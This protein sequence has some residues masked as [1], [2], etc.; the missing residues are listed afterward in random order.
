MAESN[1]DNERSTGLMHSNP[2]AS[3]STDRPKKRRRKKK[4]KET[5][6]LRKHKHRYFSHRITFIFRH[7]IS[8]EIF[9]GFLRLLRLLRPRRYK[10]LRQSAMIQL[11]PFSILLNNL[12]NELEDKDLQNLKNVCTEF[13]PR[14]QREKIKS[15]WEVFDI[16]KCQNVIGSK[17][18]KVATLL[19]II[20]ELRRRD[21]VHM[22]KKHIQEHY[23]QP[24]MV[25]NIVSSVA[26]SS[27]PK[28]V[29]SSIN[30]SDEQR[31]SSP[32]CVHDC[33][34][35]KLVC[36]RS[37]CCDLSCC[38]VILVIFFT[39]FTVVAILAWYADIPQITPY[40]N[41]KDEL[42]KAGPYIIGA[43]A[44][45]ALCSALC[46]IYFLYSRRKDRPDPGLSCSQ[47]DLENG[48]ISNQAICSPLGSNTAS[49][50]LCTTPVLTREGSLSSN[51]LTTSCSLSSVAWIRQRGI[52]IPKS[53]RHVSN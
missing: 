41:S 29:Y 32:C 48:S 50:S 1:E 6:A 53:S 39:I 15:G 37:P 21:L 19:C 46:K 26:D 47:N 3:S 5:T 45:S 9:R 7:F 42:R 33:Y 12:S 51:Q 2:E 17:P 13:I 40:L 20:K 43:L 22:I 25:L 31:P 24:E 8:V 11:D 44:F 28:L 16:L 27:G 52:V 4:E 18:E 49:N 34:C 36:Y 38:C 35:C 23:E 10:R 14:R 30:H